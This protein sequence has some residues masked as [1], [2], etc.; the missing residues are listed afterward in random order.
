MARDGL[1]DVRVAASGALHLPCR[2][3]LRRNML[4]LFFR[5]GRRRAADRDSLDVCLK[6][7]TRTPRCLS[8]RR[9]EAGKDTVVRSGTVVTSSSNNFLRL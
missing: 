3:K 9:A 7:S 4:S 5:V 8:L 1:G 2:F 6:D